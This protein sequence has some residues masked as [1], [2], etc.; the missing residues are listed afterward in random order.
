MSSLKALH[1]CAL[2]LRVRHDH[3][4]VDSQYVEDHSWLGMLKRFK[5]SPTP[6]G[7][8]HASAA[9]RKL[10]VGRG[11]SGRCFPCIS[12]ESAAFCI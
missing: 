10:Q 4:V 5:P 2:Q 12:P 6:P 1:S 9:A 11:G 3:T 8:A 7:A